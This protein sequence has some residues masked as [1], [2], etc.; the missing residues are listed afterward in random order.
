MRQSPSVGRI[1]PSS[2][3]ARLVGLAWTVG[4]ARIEGVIRQYVDGALRRAH[5]DK[6]EDGTFCAEVVDLPGVL[7]AGKT[8][9]ECRDHLAEVVEEWVLIRVSRGL[10]VPPLDDIEVRVQKTV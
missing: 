3:S 10:A 9:E 6:L 7:A 5:Y 2:G 1:S 4:A 8:L